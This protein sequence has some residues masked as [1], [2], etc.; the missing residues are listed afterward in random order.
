MGVW[1]YPIC[2]TPAKLKFKRSL[3]S[4]DIIKFLQN[5]SYFGSEDKD[6]YELNDF[7]MECYENAKIYGYLTNDYLQNWKSFFKQIADQHEWKIK[8]ELHFFCKD[9][10]MPY[11]FKWNNTQMELYVGQEFNIYYFSTN[12]DY[13]ENNSHDEF[14]FDEEKYKK[15]YNKYGA[16]KKSNI[17]KIL[18]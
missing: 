8:F 3:I 10:N 15:N 4:T 17:E 9:D 2:A 5:H 7:Q 14:I 11:M 18:Y 1:S 6:E 16:L 12:P 13:N